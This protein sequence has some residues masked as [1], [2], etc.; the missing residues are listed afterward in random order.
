MPSP[1]S[2]AHAR[3]VKWDEKTIAEHDLERGTRMKIDEPKTPFH[4]ST[5]ELA[6]LEDAVPFLDIGSS[7][8]PPEVLLKPAPVRN[9]KAKQPPQHQPQP[10]QYLYEHSS[11]DEE[12]RLACLGAGVVAD[13]PLG[14][15]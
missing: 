10:P 4:V 7:I 13:M 11:S 14:C 3:R 5:K 6:E 2:S 12:V 9:P 1:K 15:R 8:K